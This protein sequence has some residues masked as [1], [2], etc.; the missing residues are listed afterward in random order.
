MKVLLLE[1]VQGTGKKNQIKEVASG[2]ARNFLFKNALAVLAGDTVVTTHLAQA[3]KARKHMEQELSDFQE[4]A[5]KI[6]GVTVEVVAKV[7]DTGTLYAAV[8]PEAI[9]RAIKKQYGVTVSAKQVAIAEPLKELGDYP[10]RIEFG[11]GLEADLMVT[12]VEE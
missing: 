9:M 11:H 10:V 4:L 12:V 3:E 8:S 6:D 7:S 2:Y 5:A 1:D